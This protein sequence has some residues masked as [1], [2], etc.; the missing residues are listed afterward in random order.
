MRTRNIVHWSDPGSKKFQQATANVQQLYARWILTGK[1]NYISKNHAELRKKTYSKIQALI[2]N[3]VQT[4]EKESV[5][6]MAIISSKIFAL[7]KSI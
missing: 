1:G 3:L 6:E 5:L 4:P 2:V 7:A